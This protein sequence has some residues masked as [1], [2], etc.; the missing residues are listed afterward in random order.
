MLMQNLHKR[1]FLLSSQP[2]HIHPA[3]TLAFAHIVTLLF[4]I[5]ETDATESVNFQYSTLP[6]FCRHNIYIALFS[7]TNLVTNTIH[8]LALAQC[9]NCK[10]IIST[11]GKPKSIIDIISHTCNKSTLEQARKQLANTCMTK[12]RNLGN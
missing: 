12:R 9:T 10:V 2:A 11:V 1:I 6:L 3:R 4:N 8:T 5:P 7:D